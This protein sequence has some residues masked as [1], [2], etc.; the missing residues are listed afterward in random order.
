[1]KNWKSDKKDSRLY[2]LDPVQ[3]PSIRQFIEL[4]KT[5]IDERIKI[6][7]VVASKDCIEKYPILL[8]WK[9]GT[10]RCDEEIQS[11]LSHLY[12]DEI[13]NRVALIYIHQV[14]NKE[15][16]PTAP[17]AK[18]VQTN[19]K[20]GIILDF[21]LVGFESPE[22]KSCPYEADRDSLKALEDFLGCEKEA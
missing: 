20:L 19:Y 7:N 13:Y 16:L 22:I 14:S 8:F 21:G 17:T 5:C 6:E 3:V 9:A 18:K 15:F 11:A 2:L 12:S 10:E 4:F 1:M